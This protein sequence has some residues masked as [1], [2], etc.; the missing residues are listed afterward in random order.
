MI[1][2]RGVSHYVFAVDGVA[3]ATSD[4]DGRHVAS[5]DE[6]GED[7]LGCA[8]GDADVFRHVAEADVGRVGEAQ[9]DL[10][11]VGEEG[12]GLCVISP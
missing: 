6:V 3:V 4:A 2:L 7:A 10:G 12:P 8:F 5:F 11:V 9:E 1:N